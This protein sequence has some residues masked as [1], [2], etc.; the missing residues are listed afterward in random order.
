MKLFRSNKKNGQIEY[1]ERCKIYRETEWERKINS[2]K[3]WTPE[4]IEWIGNINCP[5]RLSVTSHLL[6][7]R[8]WPEWL[9]SKPKEYHERDNDTILTFTVELLSMLRNKAES[10][11][12]GLHQKIWTTKYYRNYAE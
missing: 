3:Y 5:I 7:I 10:L 9:P 2:R 11:S 12:P 1:E 6:N 8:V 4:L